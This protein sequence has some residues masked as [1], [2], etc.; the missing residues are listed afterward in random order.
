MF[1]AI[2]FSLRPKYFDETR[3]GSKHAM[4]QKGRLKCQGLTPGVVVLQEPG[5][6]QKKYPQ[7]ILKRPKTPMLRSGEWLEAMIFPKPQVVAQNVQRSGTT[8]Q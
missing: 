8:G 1:L 4:R 3:T 5:A 7:G 6:N 2:N